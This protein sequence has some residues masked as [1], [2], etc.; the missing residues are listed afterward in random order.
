MPLSKVV[1]L[2]RLDH[3]SRLIPTAGI[4][5][6]VTMVPSWSG[7]LYLVILLL[8]TSQTVKCDPQTLEDV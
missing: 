5:I 4:K 3:G 7:G 1:P 8:Q 6:M 2:G